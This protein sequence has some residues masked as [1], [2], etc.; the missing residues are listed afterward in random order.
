MVQVTPRVGLL[1]SFETTA[2][3]VVPNPTGR[4]WLAVGIEAATVMVEPI[5]IFPV[6]IVLAGSATAVA[7]ATNTLPGATGTLFGGV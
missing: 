1:G 5:V 3:A 4:V 6:T 7:R 2:A